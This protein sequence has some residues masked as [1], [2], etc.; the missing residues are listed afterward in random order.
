M[1]KRILPV[2]LAL[3]MVM[4]LLP[5]AFAEAPTECSCDGSPTGCS[6]EN[7][8]CKGNEGLSETQAVCNTCK[9]AKEADDSK[10]EESKD[11]TTTETKNEYVSCAAVAAYAK[12]EDGVKDKEIGSDP[13]GEAK[14]AAS[15][16]QCGIKVTTVTTT[17]N[18]DGVVTKTETKVTYKY[19]SAMC[20]AC[21]KNATC[22]P[23]TGEDGCTAAS[24]KDGCPVKCY[25]CSNTAGATKVT[26]G[27]AEKA[28]CDTCA[29]DA[30]KNPC[31][32]GNCSLPAGHSAA[33]NNSTCPEDVS[34]KAGKL[35]GAKTHL[36]DC[37]D[38]CKVLDSA[39]AVDT[40]TGEELKEQPDSGIKC[41]LSAGHSTHHNNT[42][43]VKAD[44]CGAGAHFP[45]KAAVEDD[46]T[47][48]DEDETAAAVP[49]CPSADTK[50]NP[51]CGVGGCTRPAKHEG[52]HANP[53]CLG[54]K[55]DGYCGVAAGEHIAG[56]KKY[57]ECKCTTHTHSASGT[58]GSWA[59]VA[60]VSP[61]AC[62]KK[63]DCPHCAAWNQFVTE[64]KA[65]YN[66]EKA[67]WDALDA[68]EKEKGTAPVEFNLAYC[69]C[70]ACGAAKTNPGMGAVVDADGNVVDPTEPT[71]PEVPSKAEDFTD[72]ED[73]MAADV[74][75]ALD[76]GWLEGYG[77]GTFNGRGVTS[78]AT[79]AAVL[80]RMDGETITGG[81]WA[82]DALKWAADQDA[83]EGIDL[84]GD[85]MARKDLVLVIWRMAGK[86]AAEKELDFTDVD[87][88]EGDHLTAMQWAVENGIVKGNG[89]GTVTPD[90]SVN[91]AALCAMLARYDALEK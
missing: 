5:V 78:G 20:A 29:K 37:A 30:A 75:V 67:A 16:C 66:T 51:V 73:W 34:K 11:T 48:E 55:D 15:G 81:T 27:E 14:C 80:A 89:D 17:K 13:H 87:G 10:E 64:R 63:I 79:I 62:T 71:D 76:K 19:A 59:N 42:V 65:A 60:F 68:T 31:G 57:V 86:P 49:G 45:G 26:V 56:C 23:C 1:K 24:H 39:K 72:M 58:D 46:P 33:H 3:C 43:C 61:G 41:T 52:N 12:T 18:A 6:H 35:C 36:E 38:R 28:I 2:L 74:Q 9:A 32:F 4:S 50:T 7:G 53:K 83:F 40:T 47:T 77:D 69:D 84:T 70:I 21:A 85:S 25:F 54:Y 22:S 91:R 82:M 90:G 8:Q 88:L 44:K